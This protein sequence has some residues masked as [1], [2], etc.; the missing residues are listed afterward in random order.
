MFREK[1]NV[2][3]NA[4]SPTTLPMNDPRNWSRSHPDLDPRRLYPQQA[5]ESRLF[6]VKD[7]LSFDK[8]LLHSARG[9]NSK[10]I[11]P[12][13]AVFAR[14]VPPVWLAGRMVFC[15]DVSCT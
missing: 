13:C 6:A 5:Y 14:H 7:T 12:R 9:N 10:T 2:A 15:G 11:I 8:L 3:V 1:L 4:T